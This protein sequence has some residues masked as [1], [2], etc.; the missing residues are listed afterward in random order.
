MQGMSSVE[1]R[2]VFDAPEL[3]ALGRCALLLLPMPLLLHLLLQ[4]GDGAK[5]WEG[6]FP[7]PEAGRHPGPQVTPPFPPSPPP[8]HHHLHLPAIT[9]PPP[10]H[11][12]L[13]LPTIT[14]TCPPSPTHAH[15]HL[16][17][18]TLTPTCPGYPVISLTVSYS[19][20]LPHS[21][22]RHQSPVWGCT[23]ITLDNHSQMTEAEMGKI[24]IF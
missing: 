1:V 2:T 7:R 11:P 19:P 5:G 24:F 4:G 23:S 22:Y 16:H 20:T 9:S 8:A 12:H 21:R 17:L 13:H 3:A 10:A 6:W 18:P 14:S 15:H